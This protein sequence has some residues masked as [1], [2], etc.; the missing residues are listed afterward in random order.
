MPGSPEGLKKALDGLVLRL[1]KVKKSGTQ[2]TGEFRRGADIP[3]LIIITH[4]VMSPDRILIMRGLPPEDEPWLDFF[5][6]I[7]EAVKQ[8]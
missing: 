4:H 5:V 1:K 2:P 8:P 7:I 6:K 3:E